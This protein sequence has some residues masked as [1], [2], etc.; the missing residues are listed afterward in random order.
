[1]AYSSGNGTANTALLVGTTGPYGNPV[2]TG[3]TSQTIQFLYTNNT[4]AT[5]QRSISLYADPTF[6]GA[7][8]ADLRISDMQF[9][10]DKA[11]LAL[12]NLAYLKAMNAAGTATLGLIGLNGQDQMEVGGGVQNDPDQ[13]LQWRSR[14]NRTVQCCGG[15]G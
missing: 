9:P 5:S 14:V 15:G 11:H 6:A 12:E 1:M 8:G 10:G 13:G 3:D 7:T 2:E 4:V